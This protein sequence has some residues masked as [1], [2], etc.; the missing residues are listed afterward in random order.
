MP[1]RRALREA[2]REP[3]AEFFSRNNTW[4][5]LLLIVLYK[6]GTPSP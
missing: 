6:M 3:L 2:V 5:L 1:R 4:L